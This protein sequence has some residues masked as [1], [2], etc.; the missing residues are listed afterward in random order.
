GDRTPES[1]SAA[2]AD[3]LAFLSTPVREA[4]RLAALLGLDF[5]VS[6]LAVVAGRRVSDL[7]PVLDEAI[8]AGI[9]LD[10]GAA[11]TFRHPLI[12]SA[13]YE[14]MPIAVRAAWHRDAARALV[15]DGAA[16]ERVARQLLPALDGTDGTTPADEWTVEWL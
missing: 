5:S 9:F 4:L 6:E 14:R 7:M 15:N 1:L 16:A 3:R 12:R 13:L 10:D 11:L 2:I 8:A